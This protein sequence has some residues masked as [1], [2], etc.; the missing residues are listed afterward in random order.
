MSASNSFG[1]PV[2][3]NVN[4]Q[5]VAFPRLTLEDYGSLEDKVRQLRNAFIRSMLDEAQV[6]GRE[7]FEQLRDNCSPWVSSMQIFGF[8]SSKDGAILAA[9][10]SLKRAGKGDDEIKQIVSAY[11]F[12]G[13]SNLALYLAGLTKFRDPEDA[14]RE[15]KEEAGE[16]KEPQNPT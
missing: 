9:T 16:G 6:K 11:P 2:V 5:E 7:R 3:E 4:G 8:L 1:S 14:L 12:V 15:G 10:M 13:L